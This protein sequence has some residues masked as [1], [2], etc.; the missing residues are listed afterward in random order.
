MCVAENQA[1][2]DDDDDDEDQPIVQWQVTV[3]V[4]ENQPASKCC[5]CSSQLPLHR[6]LIKKEM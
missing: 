1:D 5:I 2:D 4:A 6:V 3:C